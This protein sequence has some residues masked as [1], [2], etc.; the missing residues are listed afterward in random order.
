MFS[1]D[2]NHSKVFGVTEPFNI[3]ILQYLAFLLFLINFYVQ[4]VFESEIS[5]REIIAWM[6]K[7]VFK[8][9][10]WKVLYPTINWIILN[11]IL[12]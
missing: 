2:V 4:G 6:L 7:L 1:D 3:S 8:I 12:G 11:A 10:E 5:W 9:A